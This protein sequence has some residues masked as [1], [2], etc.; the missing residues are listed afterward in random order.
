MLALWTLG[1][2]AARPEGPP[3]VVLIVLDT[4]RADV[5]GCYGFAGVTTPELDRLAARGVRFE[6]AIA[7]SSWTRPSV[8]TIVTGRYPRTLGLYKE[9]NQ[10]IP[11]RFVLLSEILRHSGYR[12]F[13][14]T[15]NPNLN[16]VFNFQQGFDVYID[17]SVVFDWMQPRHRDESEKF[18]RL[19]S[20]RTV[21]D[22]ALAWVDDQ[23]SSQPIYLQLNVAS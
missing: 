4:L 19:P 11:D 3:N 12:T 16:T 21:Y 20:A 1:C 15:A 13:G 23:Q 18:N 2:G 14:R 7:S 10:I 8:G 17:S 6:R 5:M 22:S 9:R